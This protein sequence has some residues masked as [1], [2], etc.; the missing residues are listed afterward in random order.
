MKCPQC[1]LRISASRACS[2]EHRAARSEYFRAYYAKH[3]A[4]FIARQ[5][6]WDAAHPEKVKRCRKSYQARLSADPVRMAKKADVL[7]RSKVKKRFGGRIPTGA[8]LEMLKLLRL[9]RQ[10]LRGGSVSSA[11]KAETSK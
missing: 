10:K 11:Y 2:E 3:R 5:M 9:F 8:V 7:W 4:T 1:G 6:K